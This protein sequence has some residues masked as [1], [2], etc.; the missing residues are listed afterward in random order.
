R[1]QRD[2][3]SGR[4]GDRGVL[5]NHLLVPP[6][7][8]RPRGTGGSEVPYFGDRDVPLR[9]QATN[10]LTDLSGRADDPE[11]QPIGF[12][13]HSHQRPLPAYTTASSSPSSS[14]DSWMALTASSSSDSLIST[15]IRISEV[16]MISI[17][18]PAAASASQNCAVTP[19]WERI[20]APTRDTLPTSSS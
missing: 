1:E 3:Q 4:V 12:R 10:H 9:K 7:Q 16:L 17:F 20:P 14:N 15:E 8:R 19:G 5:D 2:I 6:G 11:T 18:T 13:P